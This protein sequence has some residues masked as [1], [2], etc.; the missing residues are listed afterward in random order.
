MKAETEVAGRRVRLTSLD[1]VLWPQTGT[2][3][4]D[5]L[6]YYLAVAPVLLP[7]LSR[8]PL[9]LVRFP[10][11]VDEPGFYQTN[12]RHHPHWVPVHP[13]P[14]P[15]GRGP[16]RRYCVVDEPA[17]LAWAA[18]LAAIELHPLLARLPDIDRPAAVVFDLDP[19]EGASL[20]D[21]CQVALWL[22]QELES[23]GLRSF[24]KTSGWA[25]LH[26]YV[27]VEV[28]TG[29]GRAK[30]F[31]RALAQRL[32]ERHPD[33][34]TERMEQKRRTGRVFVDWG[35]ND[36]SK[37]TVA[38]YSL[39]ATPWPLVSTPLGWEEVE[40]ALARSEMARLVFGP[41]SVLARI[42]RAGDLFRPVLEMAQPLP[43]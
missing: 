20:L 30:P 8:R 23:I 4:G 42:E 12:I 17:A 35:Q 24:P 5:M 7:H 3:K 13:V 1:R 27:P 15:G 34:V 16:G 29:Y 9:T 43:G 26:V 36:A 2:T 22:R 31:A 33:R 11:G 37:S 40:E 14:S 38:P 10:G 39:R 6:D 18:N 25:G 21:C 41:A 28:S 19:G 32:A